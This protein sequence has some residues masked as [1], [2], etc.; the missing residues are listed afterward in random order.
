MEH[1]AQ[2]YCDYLIACG[3]D[4]SLKNNRLILVKTTFSEFCVV[5]KVKLPEEGRLELPSFFLLDRHKY[6]ALAHIGLYE[7]G[8]G[9]IC[10]GEDEAFSYDFGNFNL[11][12]EKS[13]SKALRVVRNALTDEE[14][15]QSELKREFA[16][17]WRFHNTHNMSVY[18]YAQCPKVCSKLSIKSTDAK[19]NVK[20]EIFAF[21]PKQDLFNSNYYLGQL[22]NKVPLSRGTKCVLLNLPSVIAPPVH[23]ED[24][25]IWWANQLSA[26]E[27]GFLS[28]LELLLEFTAKRVYI[29]CCTVIDDENVWFGLECYSSKKRQIPIRIGVLTGWEFKAISVK[30]ISQISIVPRGG[31]DTGLLGCKVCVVGCGSVG[32]Y[33]ADM[34]ASSG[35]GR[36]L[37]VDNDRLSFE[38]IYRHVLPSEYLF[39]PKAKSLAQWL[40]NK[41]PYVKVQ[42]KEKLLLDLKGADLEDVDLIIIATGNITHERYFNQRMEEEDWGK[43]FVSCWVEG[44]GVGGHAAFVCPRSGGCLDCLFFDNT[45]GQKSLTPCI[46]FIKSGQHILKN[47]AGCGSEYMPFSSLD[48]RETASL[49]TRLALRFLYNEINSSVYASWKGDDR[50]AKE[51]DIEL[52][53]R[54]YRF[55]ENGDW[56]AISNTEC[57]I[58]TGKKIES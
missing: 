36:L 12:L 57:G 26:C 51:N 37:L 39:Q 6:G 45:S 34:L 52:T 56:K 1:N 23:N 16:G 33:I 5:I 9:P 2:L 21:E 58:C 47:Y 27:S 20:K 40:E 41:Y 42:N 14:Y 7:G 44:L 30:P 28:E 50:L 25:S 17:V 49:A 22:L 8:D 32:G 19:S 18:C 15:N 54:F 29:L 55:K 4:A 11:V 3:Y 53:H 35:I 31:G 13:L 46:A 38:N 10:I 43:P 24:L 48:A